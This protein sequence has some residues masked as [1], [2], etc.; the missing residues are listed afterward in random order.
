MPLYSICTTCYNSVSCVDGFMEPFTKLSNDY[1]LVIV[2]VGS[3]DETYE[4]LLQYSNLS[5]FKLIRQKC[6]RGKGRQIAMEAS[7][8][9]VVA[10]V[11]FDVSYLDI[12]GLLNL[13]EKINVDRIY[14][15]NPVNPDCGTPVIIGNRKLFN[16]LKGF[17][18]VN[19][20]DDMYFFKKADSVNLRVHIGLN[21]RYM[22]L[23]IKDVSSSTEKRYSKNFLS[24]LNR[25]ILLTRDLLF[26]SSGNYNTVKM[27]YKLRGWRIII[28]L[29]PEYIL[30]KLLLPSVKAE[31]LNKAIPE[32]RKRYKEYL[33]ENNRHYN[34]QDLVYNNKNNNS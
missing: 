24:R 23:K 21:F 4:K 5:N 18:D 3:S 9:P 31:K 17:G 2:D 20:H 16:I 30:G 10:H 22:C 1:E 8:A 6:S 33:E 25:R 13:Y 32:I 28:E 26:V 34:S 29:I 7:S 19:A 15:F 11:D 27:E 12:A 14:H